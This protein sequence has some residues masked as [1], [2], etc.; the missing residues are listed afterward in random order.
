MAIL[1]FSVLSIPRLACADNYAI[2]F[3]EPTTG[4]HVGVMPAS[5]SFTYD[6]LAGF[7]N[8]LVVWNGATYDLTA[9]ANSP[10]ILSAGCPGEA[11]TPQFGFALMTASPAACPGS[12]SGLGAPYPNGFIWQGNTYYTPS[13]EFD[14]FTNSGDDNILAQQTHGNWTDGYTFPRGW[15]TLTDTTAGSAPEP[16]SITLLAGGMLTLAAL[17]AR[18]RARPRR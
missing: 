12:V 10:T 13:F 5:G 9:A 14:V 15:W 8:F 2:N 17:M 3:F 4:P 11:A 16:A 1:M 7:S 18:K 6:P